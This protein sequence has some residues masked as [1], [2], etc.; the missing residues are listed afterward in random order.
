MVPLPATPPAPPLGQPGTSGW[1]SLGTEA[2]SAPLARK[3]GLAGFLGVRPGAGKPSPSLIDL[4][5]TWSSDCGLMTIMGNEVMDANGEVGQLG[6]DRD[7]RLE[8]RFAGEAWHSEYMDH[9]H[10]RWEGDGGT[11]TR[12]TSAPPNP[13]SGS[14]CHACPGPLTQAQLLGRSVR[15]MQAEERAEREACARRAAEEQ[16]FHAGPYGWID[17]AANAAFADPLGGVVPG[18]CSSAELAPHLGVGIPDVHGS[19]AGSLHAS[20]PWLPGPRS[21]P[22][23]TVPSLWHPPGPLPMQ[24]LPGGIGLPPP[25]ST[26]GA[27]GLPMGMLGAVACP[28]P[29]PPHLTML[30]AKMDYLANAVFELQGELSRMMQVRRAGARRRAMAEA[31]AAGAAAAVS[32]STP[33]IE[34]G[35]P[36]LPPPGPSP[37]QPGWPCP[38]AADGAFSAGGCASG[39]SG[40]LDSLGAA[41][42]N[43]LLG[44]APGPHGRFA[45]PAATASG[46][47]CHNPM[48]FTSHAFR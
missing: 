48:G 47:W 22:P 31:V 36:W 38:P 33:A 30:E 42:A 10:I 1:P 12:A 34:R 43:E 21:S 11:W 39:A 35:L 18:G 15:S 28:P 13:S 19:Y 41:I 14:A 37:A 27:P 32:T 40:H 16:A 25:M 17:A 3:P 23:P 29:Q 24:R 8:L 20:A 5:G 26:I 9:D 4:A 44:A 7:G 45:P 6:I 46:R 2:S